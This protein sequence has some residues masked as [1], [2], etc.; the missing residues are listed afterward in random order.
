MDIE[1]FI[2]YWEKKR[3]CDSDRS[4]REWRAHELN[5]YIKRKRI[6]NDEL[7]DK[8]RI[9]VG[10]SCSKTRKTKS[11]ALESGGKQSRNVRPE[12]VAAAA[13]EIRG[14]FRGRR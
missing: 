7:P 10:S 14:P 11:K 8:M 4:R 13:D 5:K 12:E 3:G 2:N 1:L 6:P 9:P